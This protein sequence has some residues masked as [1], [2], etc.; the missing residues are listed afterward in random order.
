M[1]IPFIP[2]SEPLNKPSDPSQPHADVSSPAVDSDADATWEPKDGSA[3]TSPDDSTA[4]ANA[5]PP[6]WPAWVGLLVAVILTAIARYFAPEFDYQ[7][8]NM[9]GVACLSLAILFFLLTLQWR[10]IRRGRPWT[11]PRIAGGVI[12]LLIVLFRFDGFSGEMFPQFSWRFGSGDERE[13]PKPTRAAGE[14]PPPIESG[15]PAVAEEI[16]SS[17]FL[18]PNRNGVYPTRSFAVPQSLDEVKLLWD[19][20]IGE[21]WSSFAVDAGIA[22][23]LEQRDDQ[24]C[25]SG[26]RLRDGALLWINQHPARHENPLGG[27]GPRST[28][29]IDDG[30]VYATTATGWLWCAELATG[31]VIW[32]QDLLAL[33]D[34]DQAAFETAAPWGYACSPLLVDGLCVVTLGGP[35]QSDQSASLIALSAGDGEVV[36]RGGDDQLSYASPALMTLDGRRQIVSVNEQ[37]VSGHQIEDGDTLWTFSWPGSSNTG[38]NCSSAVPVGNDGVLVG[39]GYGGGSALVRVTRDDGGWETEDVWRSHRVLKTKF[40]H[41]CVQGDVG[42]GISN[43]MLQAVDLTDATDFWNQPRRSRAAQGQVVLVDDTLVVQDEAGDVVFVEATT[44]E[45]I[46][47]FR[48]PALQAK[49]WNIPTVAGRYLLIRNDRQAICFELPRR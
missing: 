20:G 33:A 1:P 11:V 19:Q 43:G 5:G 48:L 36:W 4:V 8:A 13:L 2:R 23:T 24:E 9:I 40:N 27:V 15:D 30:R 41:T 32:T 29:T 12:V 6:L 49:T 18:G 28:P 46:E 39:K 25:L 7:N 47:R 22:V 42:Y 35:R 17:Q 3:S 26:Y 44:E 14:T 38:A 45:Y 31:R 21:G 34:W 10:S 16:V 37:T